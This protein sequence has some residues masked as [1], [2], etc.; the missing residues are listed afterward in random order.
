MSS[1]EYNGGE[2][3]AEVLKKEGIRYIFGLPGGHIYPLI[4]GCEDRGIKYIGVRHEMTAAFMAEGWAL[5]TGQVGVCTATAGPGFTNLITGLANSD[6]GGIPVLCL[7][8]KARVTENDRN[9]LQDFNQID[10]IKQMTKHARVVLEAQRIPEYVGRAISYAATGRPG[11]VYLEIP[12]DIMEAKVDSATVEFQNI[13]RT[14]STPMGCPED[15]QAAVELIEKAEKPLVVAGGGVWWSQAQ[16]E[17][18][19]FVEKSGIP[20]FTRNAARGTV[21]DNH[22]LHMGIAAHMHPLFH[23]AL[24]EADCVIIVGTRPGYTLDKK[25]FIPAHKIIRVDI[26]PAEL[27][28]QLDIDVGIVGDAKNVLRQLTDAIEKKEY[29]KWLEFIQMMNENMRSLF[30]P[31]VSSQDEPI[32]PMR[33][34]SEIANRVDQDTIVVIDGGDAAKWGNLVIPAAGPGQYLS[35]AGTSFGPLGVGIPYAMAAKLAYPEKKVLLLTGDGAFGYGAMEYDTAIRYNIPFTTVILN[36]RC[37]GMIKRSE[38]SKRS[39]DKEF[40]GLDLSLVRYEKIVEVF[41]GHGEF[42]TRPQ[43]IGE[44]LDRALASGKPAC[45]NVVT[46]V[47]VG[48]PSA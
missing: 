16:K 6:R 37:W 23:A 12:R 17:L 28:N 21:P 2:F 43:D 34:V 10:L 22:P 32:N 31:M 14:A 11:P 19:D 44:A 42:V 35:I 15:I 13:Y 8:G 24:S 40:I 36:D 30:A 47:N 45:V 7:A 48:P 38:A 33:L 5:A 4:E 29:P 18:K 39:S 41:G 26:D 1:Q 25:V 27:T 20:L 9:A 3:A 46:D